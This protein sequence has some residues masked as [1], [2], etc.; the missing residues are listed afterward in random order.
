MDHFPRKSTEREDASGNGDTPVTWG[1]TGPANARRQAAS[2]YGEPAPPPRAPEHNAAG[3]FSARAV[4]ALALGVGLLAG[5]VSGAL[6]AMLAGGD[7]NDQ[8]AGPNALQPLT[9]EQT[10]AI[11]EAAA[12]ARQSVVRIE[13]TRNV[14]GG[15]ER[16]IGSG[17][18]LDTEGHVVT[19]AHVVIGTDTLNV[20]LADGTERA[21]ILIAHDYPFSDV[22]VLQIGPGRLQPV[23][24]GDA[25]ALKLGETLIAIGNPLSEYEGSISVGVVSGLNRVRF[26]DGV[27]HADWIQTDAAINS[28][29]S[30]GALV[31]LKGQFARHGF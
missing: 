2:A 15:T 11:A 12:A 25:G 6:A 20:I 31:N 26:V 30:G 13:S 5:A 24:P 7:S 22:A 8:E 17:V 28:G 16:D 10:S 9:V 1:A 19:N 23:E 21:A 27:R 4:V 14:Q 3:G 18:L 29:N